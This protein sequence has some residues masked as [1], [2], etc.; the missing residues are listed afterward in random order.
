MKRPIIAVLALACGLPATITNG[1][2]AAKPA[3]NL[4]PNASFEHGSAPRPICTPIGADHENG[5]PRRR[6]AADAA[7][8]NRCLALEDNTPYFWEVQ[9]FRAA[10][11]VFSIYLK[12]EPGQRALLGLE[13]VFFGPHGGARPAGTQAKTIAL[14]GAWTRYELAAAPEVKKGVD[15]SLY[16]AWVQTPEGRTLFVDAAQL[17]TGTDKATAFADNRPGD[18]DGPVYNRGDLRQVVEND[19]VKR[20]TE[21]ADWSK[22]QSKT[23]SVPIAVRNLTEPGTPA[24]IGVP[25]PRGELYHLDDVSV[26]DAAGKP[27]LFQVEAL[28]RRPIDGSITSLL[29]D[30]Q[31]TADRYVLKYGPGVGPKPAASNLI[32]PANQDLLL[33]TGPLSAT[34]SPT[35]LITDLRGGKGAIAAPIE[36]LTQD[37]AGTVFTSRNRAP[38]HFRVE[39]NGPLRATVYAYGRHAAGNAALLNYELRIHAFRGKDYLMIEYGFEN[40]EPH[41]NTPVAGVSL[42]LPTA[43]NGTVR[44]ETPQGALN[45]AAP[46]ALT[47][48]RQRYGAGTCTICLDEPSG[49]RRLPNRCATG[50]VRTDGAAVAVRD[51]P[52]LDPKAIRVGKR[53]IDVELWPTQH[54]HVIDLTFGLAS[55]ICMVYGPWGLADDGLALAQARPIPQ[56]DPEWVAQ[57][58]VFSR[59]LTAAETRPY[60]PRFEQQVSDT[61]EN[62]RGQ[63]DI[64]G[65]TGMFNR[66]SGGSP[67]WWMNNETELVR[68][69]W[70]QYLRT[71]DPY[72]FVQ[73]EQHALHLRDIDVLHG[74]KADIGGRSMHVHG[75]GTHTT[76][77]LHTGHYWITGLIWHYLLTGDKRT[78]E[79]VTDLSSVLMLKHTMSK[80]KGRERA[81]LL[82]HLA[83]LY[84]LTGIRGFREAYTRHFD[85]GQP[86]STSGYYAGIGL[87]CVR[88]WYEMTGEQRFLDRFRA[89]AEEI[90]A[91]RAAK[92]AALASPL[93]NPI[94]PGQG[95]TWT[96]FSAAAGASALLNDRKHLEA[97]R[98][99]MPWMCTHASAVDFNLTRGAEFFHAARMFGVKECENMPRHL[100][101]LYPFSGT[102]TGGCLKLPDGVNRRTARIGSDGAA[103]LTVD[104]Y[105][106]SQFRHKGETPELDFTLT[107]PDGAVVARETVAG[108]LHGQL[109][110]LRIGAPQEGFYLL[111]VAMRRNCWAAVSTSTPG[112]QL[113]AEPAY[114][115]R[116][117]GGGLNAS[118]FSARAPASGKLRAKLMW[119]TAGGRGGQTVGIRVSAPNGELIGQRRW[120][121]PMGT[122]WDRDTLSLQPIAD[123]FAFDIP[124]RYRGKTIHL[125]VTA[126]KWVAF[127]F[128]GLDE[129]WLTPG[130]VTE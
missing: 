21:I 19:F 52:N 17:E 79:V 26:V 74:R 111:D 127:Q 75:G 68:A 59:Y 1:A 109:R 27:V 47:Q 101:G 62:M 126:A 114:C 78:L 39:R 24:W 35:R 51:F 49:S 56:P 44:F 118:R 42:R 12:G 121:V 96:V 113:S 41:L 30:L 13:P 104:I 28:A 124:A 105:R 55:Q 112:A 82:L 36:S 64:A 119:R 16:R 3:G 48:L 25:F 46:A 89:D 18:P 63:R 73:A 128:E 77:S 103:P 99:Y 94:Q 15:M 53:H 97:I 116:T 45:A 37:I 2:R 38:T 92:F 57:S 71:Y 122:V 43:E 117:S 20:E 107:A 95:R 40:Q 5:A 83:D 84:E 8:G 72:W 110:R 9:A 54:A 7:H 61:F 60:A 80:Y 58:G 29:V 11:I 115:F 14:S 125:T 50:V 123:S 10:P 67:T 100:L 102:V 23:G 85:Y 91:R 69:V 33:H 65:I 86:T 32:Q 120:A 90:F 106:L 70:L 6:F 108:A 130:H 4:L 87:E 31:P 129:P 81:R 76:F 93:E 22:K 88:R 66:G 98:G 34:V